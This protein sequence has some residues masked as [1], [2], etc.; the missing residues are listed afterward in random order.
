MSRSGRGRSARNGGKTALPVTPLRDALRP[1]APGI[2]LR[3]I[4]NALGLGAQTKHRIVKTN[5]ATLSPVATRLPTQGIVLGEAKNALG[6]GDQAGLE[7]V[8]TATVSPDAPRAPT[9]EIVVREAETTAMLSVQTG[10]TPVPT[11]PT[12]SRPP[13]HVREWEI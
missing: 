5:S 7:T 10:G 6:T 4:E 9:T 13:R 8:G 12:A 2:V 1:P 11:K 3:E